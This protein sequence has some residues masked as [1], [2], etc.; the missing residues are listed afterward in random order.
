MDVFFDADLEVRAKAA[1]Q[2]RTLSGRFPYGRM[3]TVKDRGRVRK[4]RFAPRA[5][6]FQLDAFAEAKKALDASIKARAAPRVVSELKEAVERRN[7]NLLS[8]HSFA[9]PLA[10]LA[11]GTLA[12]R[13]S[14]EALMFEA[15]L[16]P[17]N[18]QPSWMRDT[19]LAIESGLA[20][21]ISPGFR[22]PPATTVPDAER[23]IDEPGNAGVQIREI[24]QAVLYE[25]SIVTRAAYAETEVE[26]R[27]DENETLSLKRRRRIWL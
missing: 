26:A 17:E 20:V 10:A 11:G 23:L 5:F 27:G 19:V 18:R 4:E 16:P 6:S 12:L 1:G 9:M 25:L 15:K 7:V 2:G 3:A 13:D 14:D 8:G 22:I 24:L 21:G